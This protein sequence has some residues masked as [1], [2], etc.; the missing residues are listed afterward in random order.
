M[1]DDRWRPEPLD[2]IER[3]LLRLD[4]AWRRWRGRRR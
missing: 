1:D 4:R 3:W 2:P